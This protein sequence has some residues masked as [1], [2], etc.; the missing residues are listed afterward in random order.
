MTPQKAKGRPPAGTAD[1]GKRLFTVCFY[2][3]G[4]ASAIGLSFA[5]GILFV[6]VLK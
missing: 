6:E 3:A 2:I 4:F 5:L 1:A